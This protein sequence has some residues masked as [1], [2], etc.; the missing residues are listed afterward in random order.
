MTNTT[1]KKATS[2]GEAFS[3][4]ERLTA[5][6]ERDDI[7]LDVALEKFERGLQL[8]QQLK[9]KLKSVE[10]KVEAIRKKFSAEELPDGEE[11]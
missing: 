8:A 11:A 7:D 5:D 2:F 6:L 3:E 4:L 9:A 10:Q 1:T